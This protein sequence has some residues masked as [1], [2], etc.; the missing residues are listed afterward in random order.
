MAAGGAMTGASMGN[1][2]VPGGTG[3]MM[4]AAVGGLGGLLGG[5][6]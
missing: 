4:G 2:M 3:A 6:L 5:L 1:M